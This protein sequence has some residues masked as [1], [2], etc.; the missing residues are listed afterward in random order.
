MYISLYMF[1]MKLQSDNQSQMRKC[2]TIH[3]KLGTISIEPRVLSCDA[4]SVSLLI[5]K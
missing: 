2:S 3:Y 5:V 1:V 4:F